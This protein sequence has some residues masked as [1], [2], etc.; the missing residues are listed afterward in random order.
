M[1]SATESPTF[2]NKTETKSLTPTAISDVQRSSAATPS[3]SAH[4]S[5][6]GRRNSSS[7]SS[8]DTLP[9]DLSTP[10]ETESRDRFRGSQTRVLRT[11]LKG[12]TRGLVSGARDYEEAR[13]GAKEADG[14]D[15]V[16]E[17]VER[18]G[19]ESAPSELGRVGEPTQDVDD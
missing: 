3:R 8:Y 9:R 15:L 14:S 19:D 16:G 12:V 2:S 10:M 1:R 13:Q 18:L 4:R 17:R 7:T 5:G 11:V 6:R